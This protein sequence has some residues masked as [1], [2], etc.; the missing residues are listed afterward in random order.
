MAM[1][2][3][4]P[5]SIPDHDIDIELPLDYHC[6]QATFD[7]DNPPSG[8]TS[9]TSS[10]QFIKLM[11]I[12]SLIQ[13]TA[14]RV[15]KAS[16]QRPE[17]LLRMIDEWVEQIPA[18]AT[19]PKCHET[20][21]CSRDWF[22]SRAADARMY[23]LRPHTTNVAT[24][25]PELVKLMAK[26]A[27]EACAIQQRIHQ[28]PTSTT[29]LE[30]LRSVFLCGLTL[31]HAVQ[32]DRSALPFS[33]LRRATSAMSN[34]LFVYSNTYKGAAAYHE[35][36]DALSD[37]II[38][39]WTEPDGATSSAPTL[40]PNL[41]TPAATPL[42][43]SLWEDIPSVMT[44]DTE[45]SFAGLLESLGL[46][47]DSF[48]PMT[49]PYSAAVNGGVGNDLD[50]SEIGGRR[51]I[52]W[53]TGHFR[54]HIER[55]NDAAEEGTA[56][57]VIFLARH[58]QGYH[59]VA[60]AKYGT[61]AWDEYW[62]KRYGDEEMTWGPDPLLTPLGMSQALAV[63]HAWK[64]ERVDDV[65]L[66]QSRYSSPLSRAASTLKI[67]WEGLSAGE[68]SGLQPEFREGWR[69][70]LGVHTCDQRRTK[71]Y[72][73]DSY[74]SFSFEAGFAKDD[75]LWSPT[76]RET[77]EEHAARIRVE[78]DKIFSTDPSTYISITAHGGVIGAF[79]RVVGHRKVAVPP[80][81]MIPIV[82]KATKP[83]SSATVRPQAHSLF[84][85]ISRYTAGEQV[86]F[87]KT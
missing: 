38:D 78:L 72:L 36:F 59:N 71:S 65:P 74:P 70:T 31:L 14:Y 21:C 64:K 20:P 57:K 17:P 63:N 32:V 1:S 83:P 49:G 73:A 69:E 81:G 2:L 58:G 87:V 39:K 30:G 25:E 19:D 50:V 51:A 7:L 13:K 22:L 60:E 26:Y 44:H 37:A 29:S 4:R 28:S 77:D 76:Y 62:S 43:Q 80:G 84:F 85:P 48:A 23:L 61:K 54:R 55:L 41:Q 3:G 8:P 45:D 86:V 18:I 79:F 40:P 56:V 52:P 27:A 9:M 34:T 67:T 75:E 53:S 47:A 12:E 46:P 10:I 42:F 66:P 15:D 5:T 11:R 35:V 16:D 33:V 82:V 6:G 68:E 24:A